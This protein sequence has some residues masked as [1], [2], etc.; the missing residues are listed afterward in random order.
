MKTFRSVK[1]IKLEILST[2]EGNS[3][4]GSKTSASS[5]SMF[6]HR[7]RLDLPEAI[8]ELVSE[9]RIRAVESDRHYYYELEK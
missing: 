3:Q 9:R 4:R 7:E 5:F 6:E 1:E 2:I 8:R